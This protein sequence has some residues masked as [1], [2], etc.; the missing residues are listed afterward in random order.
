[1]GWIEAGKALGVVC[2]ELGDSNAQ[3]AA[4]AILKKYNLLVQRLILNAPA[5][6]RITVEVH[7]ASIPSMRSRNL[8]VSI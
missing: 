1:V 4:D 3:A 8:A 6:P 2:A 5:R 7:L